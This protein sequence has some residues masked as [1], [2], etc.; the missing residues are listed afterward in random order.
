MDAILPTEIRREIMI[1]AP[2]SAVWSAVASLDGLMKWF[3][4]VVEG[5]F[6]E[7]ETL[8]LDFQ[9]E[10]C[11]DCYLIIK[12]ISPEDRIAFQWHPGE[13]CPI[14]AFPREEMTTITFELFEQGDGTNLVLVESGFDRVP[15][16][17]R[18]RCLELNSE[19]WDY[20]LKE[21]ADFLER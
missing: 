1:R 4:V 13:D 15:M 14:D 2:K 18:A 19:G 5:V 8:R 6:T 21:L 11:N 12:E 20:E 16:S 3:A 10:N 9:L 17:R 7:G